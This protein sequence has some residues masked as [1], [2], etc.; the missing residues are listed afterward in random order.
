MFF[1][2]NWGYEHTHA[3]QRNPVASKKCQSGEAKF[4]GPIQARD[5]YLEVGSVCVLQ[6]IHVVHHFTDMK[7][8]W[9]NGRIGNHEFLDLQELRY[10]HQGTDT[11]QS[12]VGPRVPP[13]SLVKFGGQRPSQSAWPSLNRNGISIHAINRQVLI[14]ICTTFLI[15]ICMLLESSYWQLICYSHPLSS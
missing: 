4:L 13:W 8:H 11:S 5:N 12:A 7:V 1:E 15:T 2:Y 10:G 14:K 3:R 6:I 9:T